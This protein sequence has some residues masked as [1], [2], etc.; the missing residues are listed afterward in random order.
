[1]IF[2]N[3]S[4]GLF[5]QDPA[6]PKPHPFLYNIIAI[7]LYISASNAIKNPSSADR[8][9]AGGVGGGRIIYS[10]SLTCV[11]LKKEIM[12]LIL[13]GRKSRETNC[14][15]M[16]MSSRPYQC[17]PK[18]LTPRNNHPYRLICF[19][20]SLPAMFNWSPCAL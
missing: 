18:I 16:D 2:P 20:I 1:M 12:G 3:T 5:Q 14:M 7:I 9:G 4:N 8:S 19:F 17:P 15:A 10:F 13:Y 11:Q 6:P